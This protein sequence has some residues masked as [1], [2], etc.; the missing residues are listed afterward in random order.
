M[1]LSTWLITFD[2]SPSEDDYSNCC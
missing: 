2:C 1:E